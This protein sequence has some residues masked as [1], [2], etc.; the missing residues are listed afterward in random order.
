MVTDSIEDLEMIDVVALKECKEISIE[1]KM[2]N[3]ETKIIFEKIKD[4]LYIDIKGIK[5]N[6]G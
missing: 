1:V 2:K 4:I 6:E 3:G 5:K